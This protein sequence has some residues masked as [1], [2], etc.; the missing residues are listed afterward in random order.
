ME[1]LDKKE[2]FKEGQY[3]KM[4]R[5]WNAIVKEF[6]IDTTGKRIKYIYD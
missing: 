2:E 3:G 5:E 4:V 6:G 1:Y